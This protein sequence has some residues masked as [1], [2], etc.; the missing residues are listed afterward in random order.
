MAMAMAREVVVRVV[1]ATRT[2]PRGRTRR[3][4]CDDA[5]EG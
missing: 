1:R 4:A 3:R 2:R 5:W